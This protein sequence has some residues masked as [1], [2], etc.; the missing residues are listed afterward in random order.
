MNTNINSLQNFNPKKLNQN[1]SFGS[2]IEY[3]PSLKKDEE[4]S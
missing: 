4:D 2:K 3:N 1:Q